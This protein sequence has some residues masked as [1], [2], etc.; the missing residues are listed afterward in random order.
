MGIIKARRAPTPEYPYGYMKDKYVF[1][2][3]L[4]VAHK[5]WVGGFG[6]GRAGLILTVNPQPVTPTPNLSL[7]SAVG[8]FCLGAG[9]SIVN[10]AQAIVEPAVHADNM[11]WGLAVLLVST[12]VEGYS[13]SVAV[14]A[15]AEGARAAGMRFWEF[16]RAGRDPTSIAVMMEDGAAVAGLLIAALA[17]KLVSWTGYMARLCPPCPLCPPDRLPAPFHLPATCAARA[18]ASPCSR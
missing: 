18:A 3:G 2:R 7:I 5:G 9:A 13:L 4:R 17:T 15:V 1:R 16:V 6:G 12:L 8:I 10:G 11:G 14:R